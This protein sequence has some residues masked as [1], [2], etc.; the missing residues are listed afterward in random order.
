MPTFNDPSGRDASNDDPIDD[1]A[2]DDPVDA[3]PAHDNVSPSEVPPA[4]GSTEHPT[5]APAAAAAVTAAATTTANDLSPEDAAL[6]EKTAAAAVAQEA[7]A[8]TA[9]TAAKSNNEEGEKPPQVTLANGTAAAANTAT[10]AANAATA[11]PA[12]V[13][14]ASPGGA[15]HAIAAASLLRGLS[16]VS[17]AT[18]GAPTP[19][20]NGVPGAG[21][22]PPLGNA[23]ASSV[24]TSVDGDL[25]AEAA[26]AAAS[27]SGS[28]SS[29]NKRAL[30]DEAGKPAAPAAKK[31]RSKKA[32]AGSAG[33]RRLPTKQSYEDDTAAAALRSLAT[34]S[35]SEASAGASTGACN[36]EGGPE[37]YAGAA[38]S[39][40][41][42][43]GRSVSDVT[44]GSAVAAAVAA[45]TGTANG[46]NTTTTTG[47]G[48]TAKELMVDHSYTDYSL[49]DAETLAQ[50]DEEQ[51]LSRSG[52]DWAGL[53]QDPYPPRPDELNTTPEE[54]RNLEVA[55]HNLQHRQLHDPTFQQEKEATV[56]RLKASF[57]GIRPGR[58][59]SGGV[60]Q[61]FPGK[62]M[63]VL[64]RDDIGDVIAWLPH[65]RA[66]QV[67][68]HKVF[69]DNI[70]PRFFKQS[71]YMSFTRQ[72][73]LWGFKRITRGQD[74]GA[75]YHE[76][77]LRGRP[78]LTLRMRRQKIKG[79]GIK[80]TPNPESEPNFYAMM[81]DR[82]LPAPEKRVGGGSAPLPPKLEPF[83]PGDRKS[84]SN[85]PRKGEKAA[86][87]MERALAR[88]SSSSSSAAARKQGN[89]QDMPPLP[90]GD[91]ETLS[92]VAAREAQKATAAAAA[93][94][95]KK[96][97]AAKKAKKT[98]KGKDGDDADGTGAAAAAPPA[99]MPPIPPTGSATALGS[100]AAAA[101]AAAAAPAGGSP[102]V[103][104]LTSEMLRRREQAVANELLLG[105]QQDSQL[106]ALLRIQAAELKQK[107]ELAIAHQGIGL[108]RQVEAAIPGAPT[109]PAISIPELQQRLLAAAAALDQ[110]AVQQVVLEDQRRANIAAL[111][112]AA[113]ASPTAGAT[114]GM[115]VLNGGGLLAASAGGLTANTNA[116]ELALLR[117][118]LASSG[119][120]LPT[121]PSAAAPAP[122]PGAVSESANI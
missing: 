85:Q 72:L 96:K 80:L 114:A 28:S 9:G 12:G 94:K 14:A 56:A 47:K 13:A 40:A 83:N 18:S 121:S 103:S 102:G 68:Q 51:G 16:T 100:T 111:M 54:A 75:Y 15:G 7:A 4:S 6:A 115:G 61:P 70:L 31:S 38:A 82:P 73:N 55:M 23:G 110:P 45:A 76:L 26:V 67:H 93:A 106:D 53:N 95:S 107:Q 21:P 89:D 43:F 59:N 65:G 36:K 90:G 35:D 34:T 104:A 58:R 64:D 71:K 3:V 46:G 86:A 84:G 118:R 22:V 24:G 113:P 27:V 78:R 116:L 25:V 29:N 108:L 32:G 17:G 20:P 99:G 105:S 37:I 98:K 92:T 79:T 109:A 19:G 69:T 39:G 49:V 52:Y 30:T 120:T 11:V 87:A 10:T 119:T 33:G 91:V 97:P 41:A 57:K 2:V 101:A 77:F 112:A 48:P 117:Q 81:F 74:A 122:A 50:L 5:S 62:L 44:A 60:V 1:M 8:T 42:A 88:V 66:F 63:Q